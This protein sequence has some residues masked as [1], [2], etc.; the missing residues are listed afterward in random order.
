MAVPEAHKGVLKSSRT[1]SYIMGGA[2][3]LYVVTWALCALSNRLVLPTS[4]TRDKLWGMS[5][6]SVVCAGIAALAWIAR[7]TAR[8]SA[9][10]SLDFLGRRR[11]TGNVDRETKARKQVAMVLMIVSSGFALISMLAV[12]I[13]TAV[14]TLSAL[15]GT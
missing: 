13:I 9:I 5:I 6:W 14:M 10:E 3:A 11:N 15:L 4:A 1:R 8:D 12:G 2:G 7:L